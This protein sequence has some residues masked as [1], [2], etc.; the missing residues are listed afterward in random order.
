MPHLIVEYTANLAEVIDTDILLPKLHD[1]LLAKPTLFPIG[2][3]RS[4]A[5]PLHAY[6]VADGSE[7]S[8]AF[9]HLTFKIG[10]GRS[11]EEKETTC[12]ELF[13]VLTDHFASE[14]SKRGI[15]LSLELAEFGEAGT[16]KKNNIH[17]RFK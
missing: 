2:G 16:L 8:D 9:V 5:I 6:Y 10:A 3:I 14:W 12:Q 17:A 11:Q 13:T 15:A 4:R 1:V 7:T